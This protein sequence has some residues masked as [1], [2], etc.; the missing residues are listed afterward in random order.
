MDDDDNSSTSTEMSEEKICNVTKSRLVEISQPRV[1]DL[2]STL[3]DYKDVFPP[4]KQKRLL[5][6]IND[7]KLMTAE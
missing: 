6:K 2:V 1:R 3:R 4:E 7:L 5:A